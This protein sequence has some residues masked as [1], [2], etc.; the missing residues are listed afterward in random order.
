ML[1]I[2]YTTRKNVHE[3]HRKFIAFRYRIHFSKIYSKWIFY[4]YYTINVYMYSYMYVSTSYVE[5]S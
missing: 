2:F 4:L 5:F 1:H 3:I